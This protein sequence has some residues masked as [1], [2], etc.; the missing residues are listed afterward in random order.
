MEEKLH[1]EMK[2]ESQEG[3]I[4]AFAA[5]KE[6][7][8]NVEEKSFEQHQED[9]ARLE[10]AGRLKRAGIQEFALYRTISQDQKLTR[11]SLKGP[12]MQLMTRT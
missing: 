8:R 1:V 9:I 4:A 10:Q 3:F 12:Q 11:V 7:A 5:K 2:E 6:A